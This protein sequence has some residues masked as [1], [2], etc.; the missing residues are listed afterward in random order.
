MAVELQAVGNKTE[1][2]AT[3]IDIMQIGTTT[4]TEI[5]IAVARD[6]TR[7]STLMHQLIKVAEENQLSALPCHLK[8][9]QC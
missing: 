9:I 5:Y 6:R 7:W 2:I 8:K 4:S 3:K 1:T